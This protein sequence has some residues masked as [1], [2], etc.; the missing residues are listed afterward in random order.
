MDPIS[1]TVRKRRRMLNSD[2]AN[3][4]SEHL[5]LETQ[6]PEN[7]LSRNEDSINQD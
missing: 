3:K 5:L 2:D 6:S 7:D 4:T 1:E